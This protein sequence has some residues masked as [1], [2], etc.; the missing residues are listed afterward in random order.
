MEGRAFYRV[1]VTRQG[2]P[3]RCAVFQS[4][5][6]A[7]LD[8]QTCVIVLRRAMFTPAR[9]ARGIAVEGDYAGILRWQLPDGRY[10]TPSDAP[11]PT[12][13]VKTAALSGQE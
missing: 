7:I 1:R 3:A 4:S 8:Q 9:D 12:G 6:H 13:R 2:T 11:V 5:G 10:T